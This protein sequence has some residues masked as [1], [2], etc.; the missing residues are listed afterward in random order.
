MDEAEDL[1]GEVAF[2]LEVCHE[3]GLGEQPLEALR[4]LHG[5]ALA[6]GEGLAERVGEH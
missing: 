2:G 6:A 5:P 4:G 1:I 3:R